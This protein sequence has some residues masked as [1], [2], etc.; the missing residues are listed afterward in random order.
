MGT[1]LDGLDLATNQKASRRDADS[2]GFVTDYGTVVRREQYERLE[3]RLRSDG[4]ERIDMTFAEVSA[5]IGAALPQSAYDHSAWWGPDPKHTQAV[6]L[7]AGYKARPNLTAQR[8]TF[9]KTA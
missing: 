9:I 4:R 2:Q 3:R 1:S 5:V 8:V 7:G 6:W